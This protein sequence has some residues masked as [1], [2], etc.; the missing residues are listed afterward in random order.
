M[1]WQ[2][3]LQQRLRR[4]EHWVAFGVIY[5]LLV[6]WNFWVTSGG[7]ALPHPQL[8]G[9]LLVTTLLWVGGLVWVSPLPWQM[10]PGKSARL[11]VGP[12]LFAFLSAELWTVLLVWMDS[13]WYRSAGIPIRMPTVMAYNLV[14]PGPILV[15]T[16]Y[17]LD[18]RERT[19]R[20]EAAADEKA[21]LAQYR[22]MQSQMSPH[23]LFNSLNGLAELI[24]KDPGQAEESVRTISSLLRQLLVIVELRSVQLEEE[25]GLLEDYLSLEAMRLGPRLTVEW[26]WDRD[27]DTELVPPLLIQPLAENAIKHGLSP[28]KKGGILRISTAKSDG[29]LILQVANTGLP[30]GSAQVAPGLG[31]GLRNLRERLDLAFGAEAQFDIKSDGDWTLATIRIPCGEPQP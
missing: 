5:V 21:R 25:R 12:L 14:I 15:L 13:R 4:P 18:R 7:H 30:M 1:D 11:T 20:A 27:L 3:A 19:E 26:A 16:G 29:N 17:F 22:L 2:T 24:H 23:V 9:S 10:W 8:W 6:A 28:S 31:I